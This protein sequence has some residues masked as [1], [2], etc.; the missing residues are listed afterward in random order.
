MLQ[1]F[2]DAV[3]NATN[4]TDVDKNFIR[5]RLT[6]LTADQCRALAEQL[7]EQELDLDIPAAVDLL[8]AIVGGALSLAAGSSTSSNAVGLKV[9]DP[10]G[11]LFPAAE[12]PAQ[13]VDS[14]TPEPAAPPTQVAQC[15]DSMGYIQTLLDGPCTFRPTS[16]MTGKNGKSFSEVEMDSLGDDFKKTRGKLWYGASVKIA[17]DAT[18]PDESLLR[19]IAEL[20][21]LHHSFLI[22]ARPGELFLVAKCPKDNQFQYKQFQLVG[23][24]AVSTC[25]WAM[26]REG[27]LPLNLMRLMGTLA[28]SSTCQFGTLSLVTTTPAAAVLSYDEAYEALKGISW[29]E[30]MSRKAGAKIAKKFGNPTPLQM[31]I[32]TY[33]D[34]IGDFMRAKEKLSGIVFDAR[35]VTISY[36][37]SFSSTIGDLKGVIWDDDDLKI[38]EVSLN[39]YLTTKMHKMRMLFLVG[40]NGSGKSSLLQALCK[41][42]CIGAQKA[43]FVFSKGLDPLGLMTKT[44]QMDDHACFAFTDFEF[45]SQKDTPLTFEEIKGLVDTN[46]P[47]NYAARWSDAVLPRWRV[48]AAAVN[49]GLDD[50]GS[51]DYGQWFAGNR[52]MPL[53]FLARGQEAIIK[54][55]PD[56]EQALARR[57]FIIRI[58]AK[59]DIGLNVESMAQE[60]DDLVDEE[61]KRINASSGSK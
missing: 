45:K 42:F 31:S 10:D 49:A 30:Y 36:P 24:S 29:K 35:D 61:L 16:S 7:S 56:T 14:L 34:E 5:S 15:L 27:K 51:V 59:S 17:P 2:A 21:H 9:L 57:V 25:Y 55:L 43:T 44:G 52:A 12:P 60:L 50:D 20:N 32:L 6:G 58:A 41:R 22:C 33:P 28:D 11:L 8:S 53:A 19:R 47:A 1:T 18:Q 3:I 40:R 54:G 37:D 13:V 26:P 4:D 48:R 38:K 46:E 39:T 23:L